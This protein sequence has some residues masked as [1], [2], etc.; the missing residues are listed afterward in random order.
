MKNCVAGGDPSGVHIGDAAGVGE[1]RSDQRRDRHGRIGRGVEMIGTG[2]HADH[3]RRAAADFRPHIAVVVPLGGDDL[4]RAAAGEIE[5]VRLLHPGDEVGVG[6][7]VR[8]RLHELRIDQRQRL[9]GVRPRGERDGAGVVV[10]V[11]RAGIQR[12]RAGDV[13]ARKIKKAHRSS[14]ND[15]IFAGRADIMTESRRAGK[16]RRAGRFPAAALLP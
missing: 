12:D 10:V 6:H 1:R 8:S 2:L 14:V 13:D 3:G 11:R 5:R 7:A 15:Q 4:L 16:S 9:P